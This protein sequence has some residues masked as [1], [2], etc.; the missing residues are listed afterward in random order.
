MTPINRLFTS[1]LTWR[2]AV[3]APFMVA[4]ALRLYLIPLNRMP[5]DSDEAIFVLMARHILA[6]ERPVF[7]YGEAYGGSTDSYFTALFYAFLGDSITVTR[8]V[9]TLEYMV[10]MLF[11]YLLAR[12]LLPGS[13]FGPAAT[14]WLM[15]LPP[16]L[17]TTWT[18]PAVLYAVVIGL[19]GVISY[20]GYRLLHEDADRLGR[21]LLFG[22]VCGLSFWTFGLLVVYM[23]PV[24]ALFLWRFKVRRVYL[25][26]L[27]AVAFFLSSLPWWLQALPGL[28]VVYNPAQPTPLPPFLMRVFAFAAITLP[29]FLGLREPWAAELIWPALAL[30]VLLFYL[31]ALLYLL[32]RRRD[33]AAPPLDSMGLALL[34]L[35]ILTWLAL[36]FGTR[37]SLDAT[38]R[39]ILPLYPVLFIA[40]ALLLERLFR[41]RKA[42]AIGALVFILTFNLAAHLK[43][44]QQV[45][46]G[47]TAQMNSALMFGNE[48]DPQL[49]DFVAQHG[50]RGYSHHWISYKIAALSHDQVIL[51]AFLPFRPDLRWNVLDDRYPPY[52][53]AVSAAPHPVYVT[54]REPHLETYLQQQ[55]AAHGITYQTHNIGPYRVY[56]DLSAAITPLQ[57][58]LGPGS[59]AAE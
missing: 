29:G 52:V 6:G 5:F 47:I 28:L 34:G 11:T 36:Y 26:L 54:H 42:A 23:V 51:A 59:A 7:F 40:A 21:W 53:A 37:F 19:G 41:W 14:L 49:I 35:Q 32:A 8:L 1:K 16:L 18:T 4:V 27:S 12:R 20:L 57:M 46:P 30:P 2:L 13:R 39:Y 9:Q 38:G 56:F 10:G 25:Y 55:L 17:L 50:G 58:N 43:A 33:P 22:A 48:F 3:I 24:F 15:A 45:P 44:V 31:A